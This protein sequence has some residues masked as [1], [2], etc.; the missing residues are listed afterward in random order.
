MIRVSSPKKAGPTWPS[1]YRTFE[2][3][4]Y[5]QARTGALPPGRQQHPEAI[6]L[7]ERSRL[8]QEGI[9]LLSLHLQAGGAGALQALLHQRNDPRCF[10]K[11]GQELLLRIFEPSLEEGEGTRF[12]L[13]YLFCRNKQ[14]FVVFGLKEEGETPG[15]I[16][17]F[18]ARGFQA[19]AGA[20]GHVLNF[21][22]DLC[23]PGIHL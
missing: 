2:L 11:V 21:W 4:L 8:P 9:G 16:I 1:F 22:M 23:R 6:L 14:T 5:A 7:Q 13:P 19:K 12:G 10:A 20:K 15:I 3:Q 18:N 17:I